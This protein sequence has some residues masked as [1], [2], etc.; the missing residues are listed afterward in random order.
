MS[1]RPDL[2]GRYAC[3]FCRHDQWKHNLIEGCP[4]CQCMA[5][6]GEA[7]ARTDAEMGYHILPDSAVLATF[8][9]PEPK[10]LQTVSPRPPALYV[11]GR[12]SSVPEGHDDPYVI[13]EE[14]RDGEDP[15]ARFAYWRDSAADGT[16][17]IEDVHLVLQRT[18]Y[19][20]QPDPKE[21]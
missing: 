16:W 17:A 12:W 8:A 2:I 9:R 20:R 19:T 21:Q 1:E 5:T 4:F 13:L 10:P 18:T 15:A 7:E 6:P 3:R 14:V 11:A